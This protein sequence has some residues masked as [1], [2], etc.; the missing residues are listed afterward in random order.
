MPVNPEDQSAFEAGRA[1][2]ETWGLGSLAPRLFELIREEPDPN[3]RLVKLRQSQEYKT[4]FA[5]NEILRKRAAAGEAGVRVL[6][7]EEYL[8]K[9]DALREQLSDPEWGLPRQFFDTPDDYARM[10]GTNMGAG[11]LQGRLKAVKDVVTDGALNGVLE[12]ARSKY[13]LTTGDLMAFYLDPDRAAPVLTKQAKAAQ[14]GAAAKRAGFGDIDTAT[15][16]RL[17]A[18]GINPDQA[19]AGFSEAATLNEL[20]RAV[21]GDAGVSREDVT[22]MVFEQNADARRR[23]ERARDARTARFQ[24]GGAYAE[25]RTGITG[26]GSANT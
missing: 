9:E 3:L 2:L 22:S 10:I 5:G 23:V 16:E 24:S 21:G 13:S 11:E 17:N 12:Y 7:E 20:T 6:S 15:A 19:Q 14:I 1:M 18:L 4:R 25:G 8:A 26:L